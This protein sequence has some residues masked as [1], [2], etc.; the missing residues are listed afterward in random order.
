MFC[1]HI[2]KEEYWVKIIFFSYFFFFL[3]F[4]SSA[5]FLFIF[6][7][8]CSSFL[9]FSFILFVIV[10]LFIFLVIYYF[11]Y[12]QLFEFLK[13]TKQYILE[14]LEGGTLTDARDL[15]YFRESE[16]AYVAREVKRKK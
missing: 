12:F 2:I 8:L 5:F 1:G 3:S 4:S 16:I 14:F 15:H 10:F 9:F 6:L 7:C 13:H 11:V